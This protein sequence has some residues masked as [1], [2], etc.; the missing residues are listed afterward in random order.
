MSPS[1]NFTEPYFMER[2]MSQPMQKNS[3][4]N[5]TKK[6]KRS[7]SN[8]SPLKESLNPLGVISAPVKT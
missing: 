4:N 7:S 2:N 5:N 3:Y 6:P 1:E 8:L